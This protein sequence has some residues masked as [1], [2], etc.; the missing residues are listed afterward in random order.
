VKRSEL[1]NIVREIV[2]DAYIDLSKVKVGDTKT[3]PETGVKSTLSAVN[4]ETGKLTWDI[5]Y[6]VDPKQVYEKLNDLVNYMSAEKGNTEL[7]K[8]K[9]ILKKLKNQ[10][11]R[12]MKKS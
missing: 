8:I 10:T 4:P 3:D 11:S 12:L 9:D 6:E 5:S 1:K 7:G 2:E